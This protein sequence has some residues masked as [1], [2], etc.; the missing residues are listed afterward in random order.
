V[1]DLARLA[2]EAYDPAK[3]LDVVAGILA[4]SER[5]MM[6]VNGDSGEIIRANDAAYE[7]F[8]RPLVGANLSRLIPE[9]HRLA[10]ER[11]RKDFMEHLIARPLSARFDV[12]ATTKD[13]GET[14]VRIG[15]TPIAQT[16]LVIA[17]IDQ[18]ADQAP[19]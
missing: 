7:L 3:G 13:R 12:P 14:V 2:S 6:V 19:V 16:R 5:A 18:L 9:R 1:G 11:H 8:G 17:E 15:L 10:H 4:Q